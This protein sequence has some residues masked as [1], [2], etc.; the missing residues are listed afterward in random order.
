MYVRCWQCSEEIDTISIEKQIYRNIIR[1]LQGFLCEGAEN[2]NC[3]SYDH[4]DCRVISILIQ[5]YKGKI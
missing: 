2:D 4:E 5:E 1:E 3:D